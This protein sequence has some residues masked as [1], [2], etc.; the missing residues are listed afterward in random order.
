MKALFNHWPRHLFWVAFV[1]AGVLTVLYGLEFTGWA[2]SIRL[3]SASMHSDDDGEAPLVLL[4]IGPLIKTLIMTGV[5]LAA[6][7]GIGRLYR[8]FTD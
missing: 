3:N 4:I 5:P 2:Q 6:S 1:S 7:L 8:R